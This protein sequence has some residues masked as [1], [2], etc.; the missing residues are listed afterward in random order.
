MNKR[1]PTPIVR[2]EKRAL[3]P[4]CWLGNLRH[5]PNVPLPLEAKT[6][7]LVFKFD[8]LAAAFQSSY[9]PDKSPG[10]G[11]PSTSIVNTHARR[12]FDLPRQYLYAAILGPDFL[13][14][15]K[16]RAIVVSPDAKR[17]TD[18]GICPQRS[19]RPAVNANRRNRRV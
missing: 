17:S 15:E 11:S 18:T 19:V 10:F 13:S 9:F 2:E 14:K 7:V 4:D 8:H 6:L 12:A 16:V 5:A 3:A 1:L